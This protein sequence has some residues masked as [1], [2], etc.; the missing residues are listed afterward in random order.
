M[1][2][3]ELVS[4]KR[5]LNNDKRMKKLHDN[6]ANL[7]Q[8]QLNLKELYD[9]IESLHKIRKTRT[10]NSKSKSLTQDL[11]KGML[12][13]G[14]TRSRIIE[15][16]IVCV[17]TIHQL[18][19][20]L[21]DLEGYLLMEYGSS[22]YGIKTKAERSQFIEA[23]VF[24]QFRQYITRLNIVK[25]TAEFVVGDIDKFAYTYRNLIEAAKITKSNLDQL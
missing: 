3:Q 6:F 14:A 8:Y 22:I 7:P 16:L 10:L 1:D 17:K 20:T 2:K 13:D 12:D 9:E 18:E 21:T 15:I 25:T 5:R 11:I 19:D 23:H 24:R 4:L